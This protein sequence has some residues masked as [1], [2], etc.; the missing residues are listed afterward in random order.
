MKG[1][2]SSTLFSDTPF[3]NVYGIA[4]VSNIKT[5]S[6]VQNPFDFNLGLHY[7][8]GTA[9]CVKVNTFKLYYFKL[10]VCFNQ[11]EL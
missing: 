7:F 11:K 9:T 5:V 4:M 2:F 1:H 8:D 3:L 6:F 10:F